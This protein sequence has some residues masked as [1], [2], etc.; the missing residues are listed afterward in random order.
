MHAPWQFV[1][2]TVD[3]AIMG[4]R[5]IWGD[6]EARATHDDTATTT[7]TYDA[8]PTTKTTRDASSTVGCVN[9][10]CMYHSRI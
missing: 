8:A 9:E 2:D 10:Y 7:T 1:G 4:N 6:G 3:E 5:D